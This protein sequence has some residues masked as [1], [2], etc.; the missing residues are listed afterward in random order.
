MAKLNTGDL[1]VSIDAPDLPQ[2][3]KCKR[4]KLSARLRMLDDGP[5]SLSPLIASLT[6]WFNPQ[7]LKAFPRA[8]AARGATGGADLESMTRSK[9]RSAIFQHSRAISVPTTPSSA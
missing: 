5:R 3:P 6:E 9:W 7:L 4:S 1:R 2:Y 8:G